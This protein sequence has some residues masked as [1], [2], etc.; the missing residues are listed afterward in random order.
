[1][2][3]SDFIR[4]LRYLGYK[5]NFKDDSIYDYLEITEENSVIATVSLKKENWV[6]TNKGMTVDNI[7]FNLIIEYAKTP[8]EDRVEQARLITLNGI[9]KRLDAIVAEAD[10]LS[11]RTIVSLIKNLM[12]D[13]KYIE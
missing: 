4:K 12:K 1:M 8:I 2:K 6:E 13:V 5:V 7:L 11:K 10:N 9:Y 3:T